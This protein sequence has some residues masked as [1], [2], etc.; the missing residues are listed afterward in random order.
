LLAGYFL[1]LGIGYILI[2]VNQIQKLSLLLGHP[3][4]AIVFTLST[5]LVSSGLGSISSGMWNRPAPVKVGLTTILISMIIVVE[6]AIKGSILDSLT[7]I[8]LTGRLIVGFILVAVP[9]FLMGV[10]FPTGLSL[11]KQRSS[12]FVAWAWV[13][14]STGS[15]LA[16]LLGVLFAVLWGFQLVFILASG[17][18]LGA[19]IAFYLYNQVKVPE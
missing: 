9:G 14:N 11:V 10:P 7:S 17:L 1:A 2:E 13:I 3:S 4:L 5:L 18:Y 6:A 8:S 15:I 16:T 19:A 12:A